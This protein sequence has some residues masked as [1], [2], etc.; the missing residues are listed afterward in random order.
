MTFS[1]LH[2]LRSHFPQQEGYCNPL[3]DCWHI[4]IQILPA[5]LLRSSYVCPSPLPE[6]S[7]QF[8]LCSPRL[9]FMN[10]VF[11]SAL[12]FI[13]FFSFYLQIPSFFL[14][15]LSVY[16]KLLVAVV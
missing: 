4:E 11:C 13:Y 7:A 10:L 2:S 9:H 3:S 8:P 16:L 12:C 14:T 5:F 15:P 1:H 6:P